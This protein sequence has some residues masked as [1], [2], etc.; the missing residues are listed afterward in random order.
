[1]LG[2]AGEV[3]SNTSV[4]FSFGLLHSDKQELD[5]QLELIYSSSVRAQ[6]VS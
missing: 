6:D 1:M 4:T 2:T 5:D 3:S